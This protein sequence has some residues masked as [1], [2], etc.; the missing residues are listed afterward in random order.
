MSKRHTVGGILALAGAALVAWMALAPESAPD[1]LYSDLTDWLG[2]SLVRDRT[3]DER[4]QALQRF[5]A[6]HEKLVDEYVLGGVTL[7]ETVARILQACREQYPEFLDSV[8]RTEEGDTP[9]ERVARNL[10]RHFDRREELRHNQAARERLHTQLVDY[11]K[12][13]E[14][15]P[16]AAATGAA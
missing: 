11:L 3:L 5:T 8:A 12:K 16:G 1:K 14:R 10:V 9:E 2:E 13:L 6:I 7:D 15:R 4:M